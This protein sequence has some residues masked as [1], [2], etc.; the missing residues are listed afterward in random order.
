MIIIHINLCNRLHGEFNLPQFIIERINGTNQSDILIQLVRSCG[1]LLSMDGI[2]VGNRRSNT[3]NVFNTF[4]I[5]KL[6]N[7]YLTLFEL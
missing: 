2:V 6:T 5:Y 3:I 7:L 1:K 4:Y